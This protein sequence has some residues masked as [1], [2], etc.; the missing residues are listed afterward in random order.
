MK[1][2]GMRVLVLNV[3]HSSNQK[4]FSSNTFFTV[5]GYHNSQLPL[6][7]GNLVETADQ[8]AKAGSGSAYKNVDN[9]PVFTNIKL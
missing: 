7:Q 9:W 5:S 8:T 1:D 2:L 6:V 4:I 3:E